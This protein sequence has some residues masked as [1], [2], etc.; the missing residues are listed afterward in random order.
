M[1][2][3]PLS[4]SELE[5]SATSPTWLVRNDHVI[6][7][8]ALGPPIDKGAVIPKTGVHPVAIK[9]GLS[10][11]VWFLAVTWL[12]FARGTEVDLALTVVTGFFVM[13]LTVFLAT[14]SMAVNAPRWRQHKASFT[15]FLKDDVRSDS[16]VRGR[17]VLI[18]IVLLPVSLA[19][20]ATLLGLI[21]SIVQG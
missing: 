10:A 15:E 18:H 11:V 13:Y 7:V 20:A 9:V 19:I 21:W 12:N 14:A 1:L 4:R 5:G 2:D 3:R 6:D 8:K 16:G 17:D